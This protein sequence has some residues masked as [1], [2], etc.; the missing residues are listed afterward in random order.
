GPRVVLAAGSVQ[1]LGE[2]ACLGVVELNYDNR[3]ALAA[4]LMKDPQPVIPREDLERSRA[5][6]V[7]AGDEVLDDPEELDRA[8]DLRQDR[9][10]NAV[11]VP[12]GLD[13]AGEW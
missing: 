2:Q 5:F 7:R 4:E 13:Q 6:R 10:R 1:V 11:G 9:G 12:I 8:P 3:R